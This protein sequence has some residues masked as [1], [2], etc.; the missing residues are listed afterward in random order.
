MKAINELVTTDWQVVREEVKAL[1]TGIADAERARL[2]HFLRTCGL[3]FM[4]L[5]IAQRNPEVRSAVAKAGRAIRD[6]LT[7]VARQP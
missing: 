3:T 1:D 5:E 6:V 2:T 4:Q 7:V